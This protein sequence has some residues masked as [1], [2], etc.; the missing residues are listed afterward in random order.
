VRSDFGPRT[1]AKL[2]RN[3]GSDVSILGLR[4]EVWLDLLLEQIFE[5]LPRVIG[6]Q[7]GW[8]R[9]FFLPD[10]ADFEEGALVARIFLPHAF[11]YWLHALEAA[12]GIE[13]HALL[14]GMQFEAA[15]GTKARRGD[16]LQHGAT[17][18]AA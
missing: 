11:L 12:S 1:W 10:D 16:G 17:L 18:R 8:C 5:C 13:I 7:V 3:G 15:L 2:A 9:G 6:A 14:A 4:S